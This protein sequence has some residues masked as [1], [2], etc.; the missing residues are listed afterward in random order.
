MIE[1]LNK[2]TFQQLMPTGDKVEIGDIDSKDFK[3]HLK[4]NRWDGE[5]FIKVGLPVTE[6]SLPIIDGNKIIWEGRDK[7]ILIYPFASKQFELGAYEYEV[8][9]DKKPKSNKIVLDIQ[10][11]GL[12]FLYQPLLT[13][14]EIE[15]GDTQPENI[16]GSYAVY[17]TT[18]RDHILGQTNYGCGKAFHIPRPK[19]FDS[20]GDWVWG[21][22]YY[23]EA[24]GLLITLIP[25]EFL[26]YAYYPIRHAAG[27]TFGYT[28]R[29]ALISSLN[30]RLDGSAYIS[31]V[32]ATATKLTAWL[33][34]TDGHASTAKRKCAIYLASDLSAPIANGTTEERMDALPGSSAADAL[35]FD[36]AFGTPP[37]IAATTLYGLYCWAEDGMGQAS[38]VRDTDAGVL[39]WWESQVYNG[40]PAL[41]ASDRTGKFSIYCTYAPEPEAVEGSASGSGIGLAE[42]TAKLDVIGQTQGS[43]IGLSEASSYLIILAVASGQGIGLAS[44]LSYLE[45][46]GQAY[47]EG[48]GLAEAIGDRILEGQA[49]GEGVGLAEA[50]GTVWFCKSLRI[51]PSRLQPSR[52]PLCREVRRA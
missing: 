4:L 25:Q 11:Q 46:T 42:T 29:G 45:I 37:D 38:M 26:E 33:L 18:K 17:H 40:W 28:S 8:I 32:T 10:S 34:D 5:C 43:G 12:K 1:Q 2:T 48:I 47:G 21:E 41:A 22:L 19:I 16:A 39:R 3:P 15:D 52:L 44:T 20:R 14:Q 35:E 51:D 36:F 23:D 7:H 27:D 24:N 50:E 30:N 31:G 9:L 6:K 13:Q 49:H